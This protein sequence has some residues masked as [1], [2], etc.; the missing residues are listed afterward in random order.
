MK[1]KEFFDSNPQ[2]LEEV[3][4]VVRVGFGKNLDFEDI[5]NHVT[6][7]EEVYLLRNRD[8]NAMASYTR[9]E[10][11]GFS[12]LIVEGI[13][14]IPEVQGK[15]IFKILTGYARN[16]KNDIIFL[17]TQ[18]PRMYRALEKFCDV[19]YP[20]PKNFSRGFTGLANECAHHS[21]SKRLLNEFADY[22]K[23]NLDEKGVV[24]EYYGELFYGVEPTHCKVS[25][26]FK[27]D[28]KMDLSKGDAILVMG[29][30]FR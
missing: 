10:F 29:Y 27:E 12:S 6:T 15:G 30:N 13:A 19:V 14:M 1:P 24:R 5:Y 20:K 18:N 9:K 7:P 23:C 3:V 28:L 17:R 8:I 11:C 21:V 16:S 22:L 25:Q 2:D 26:F 4:K